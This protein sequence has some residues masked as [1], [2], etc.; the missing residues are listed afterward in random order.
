MASASFSTSPQYFSPVASC[1]STGYMVGRFFRAIRKNV[2]DECPD[3]E[4]GRVSCE[5]HVQIWIIDTFNSIGV[6][7]EILKES[8]KAMELFNQIY[9]L[10]QPSRY[11][12]RTE[13]VSKKYVLK[14]NWKFLPTNWKVDGIV[15]FSCKFKPNDVHFHSPPRQSTVQ[16]CLNQHVEYCLIHQASF[17][18]LLLTLPISF[19]SLPTFSTTSYATGIWD[20]LQSV[21]Y[22]HDSAGDRRHLRNMQ[23]ASPNF[24]S[25]HSQ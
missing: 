8:R 23:T 20:I 2:R 18:S 16:M 14:S 17:S 5:D 9:H 22:L 6:F 1:E 15:D 11:I 21:H 10:I 19:T 25:V 4:T 12:R 3:S 24:E 13:T 7:G